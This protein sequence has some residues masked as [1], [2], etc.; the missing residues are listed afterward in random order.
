[1]AHQQLYTKIKSRLCA[2]DCR[3]SRFRGHGAGNGAGCAIKNNTVIISPVWLQ[4]FGVIHKGSPLNISW[5]WSRLPL[6][7]F[8]YIGPT[9]PPCGRSHLDWVYS[10]FRMQNACSLLPALPPVPIGA[11]NCY[12]VHVLAVLCAVRNVRFHWP[13]LVRIQL[14]PS[15]PPCGL[16]LWMTPFTSERRY[17]HTHQMEDFQ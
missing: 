5:I 17:K 4:Q 15:P 11:A 8:V 7:I 3:L 1:M 2:D 9:S 10:E 14:D 16:P 6:S 12:R 13:P